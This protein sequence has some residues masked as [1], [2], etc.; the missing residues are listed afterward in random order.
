MSKITEF[1]TDCFGNQTPIWKNSAIKN[2]EHAAL[3]AQIF[4]VLQDPDDLSEGSACDP[5]IEWVDGEWQWSCDDPFSSFSI[6][7]AS[8]SQLLPQALEVQ[9]EIRAEYS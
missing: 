1:T 2:L 6:R 9:K 7:A 5:R 4:V 3:A 8:L